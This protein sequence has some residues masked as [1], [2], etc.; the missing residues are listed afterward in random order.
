MA[1]IAVQTDEA[2][3]LEQVDT[4]A[5]VLVVG[6][7]Q[8]KKPLE[9]IARRLRLRLV[10]AREYLSSPEVAN[11]ARQIINLCAVEDYL[12]QGYYV[13]LL[14]EARGQRAVPSIDT[15]TG[16]AWKKIYKNHLSELATLIDKKALDA[17]ADGKN[18]CT[19]E[20][21]FGEAN[22]G[23]AKRLA[24]RAFKLFP[25]PILEVNIKRLKGGWK[26]EYIWPLSST[27]ISPS[28]LGRFGECLAD[29]LNNRRN[30]ASR[31]RKTMFDLA[32]LFDPLE[33]LPPSSESS[34][35][36]F[37]RAAE[38]QNIQAEIIS[39]KDLARLSSFDALFI[40]ETTNIDNHTFTF[41]R[42]AEARGMPV[43]DDSV[44]ILRCSNKVY[45]REALAR[46]K[47][48]TPK[49]L[50]I[51]KTTLREVLGQLDFPC[52]LKI[53]DGSFSRGVVKVKNADEY[54]EQA[55]KMLED[56][57]IILAQEYLYTEFDW[58]IGVLDGRPLFACKYHMAKGH[59]QIYNHRAGGRTSAGGF[60]TMA[61][62]DAP[63]S[64]IK[65][66]VKASLQMGH[67]LYGVDVK[68][69]RG[70]A[71]VIEVNDNPNIDAG[72][73]DKFI[74]ERMYD[75]VIS[76]FRRRILIARG[77]AEMAAEKRA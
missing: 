16:L 68:E 34:V 33:K 4:T 67:G 70:I 30:S 71:H 57:F 40:R 36:H 69:A 11:G 24:S 5:P 26:I 23:W 43:I 37:V 60:E 10:S 73:E 3:S 18:S 65:A 58:R 51:T 29:H 53:P 6:R 2:A 39:K 77:L 74:G 15:V 75:E 27:T 17:F 44:S 14:A 22:H 76:E 63:P 12:S 59:W 8:D 25:A 66:A 61:V 62:E 55:T 31:R 48:A 35:K 20:I 47:I 13:S 72:I 41:A 49:T 7:Q 52:V 28:E 19:A 32:I 64:V 9:E 21:F 1:T 45:L 56:S 54:V 38:R 50:L 46:A 42:H